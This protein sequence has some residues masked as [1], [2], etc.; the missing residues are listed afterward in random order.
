MK[1]RRFLRGSLGLAVA[2]PFGAAASQAQQVS[3]SALAFGT[4]VKVT[5]ASVPEPEAIAAADAALAEIRA[6]EAA[7]G[8]H[9]S[10][11]ALARLNR[12]GRIDGSASPHLA[13]LMRKSVEWSA[14]TEGAF[15]VTVQPLWQ[16]YF[17]AW[18]HGCL[19]SAR[20]LEHARSLIGWRDIRID[21][22]GSVAFMRPGMK[23]TLNGLAQGYATDRAWDV[24]KARGI[25]HALVDAGEPRAAGYAD[26]VL[27]GRPWRLGLRDSGAALSDV[28]DLRDAALAS[29]G[30]DGFAFT[31]DRRLHHILDPHSGR[32]PNELSAVH[33][34]AADACTADALS[35]ACM[36]MGVDRSSELVNTL[37]DTKVLMVRK[38]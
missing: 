26:G 31:P 4:R 28:I 11:S 34:I 38:E 16:R 37:H 17:A 19:P 18:V 13:T 9:A 24:L 22:D 8:L 32:S 15:D 25:V 2:V 7:V 23:A 27:G 10:N 6:I 30:D 33:V 14:R 5:I 20:E 35:T 21:D 29:S 36:V 12:E 3:R 1:R